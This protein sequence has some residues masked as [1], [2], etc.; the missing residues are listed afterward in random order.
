LKALIAYLLA[1]RRRAP[2]ELVVTEEGKP[3]DKIRFEYYF[4]RACRKAK[5]ANFTFHDLRHCRI[6]KWATEGIPTAAAMIAAGH[7][8]VAA[9]HELA[10]HLI[11]LSYER[12]S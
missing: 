11:N 5:V 2:S 8:S 6:S 12:A 3:L 7:S 4:R 9:E 1:E 10:D